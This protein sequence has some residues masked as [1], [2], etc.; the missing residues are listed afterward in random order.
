MDDDLLDLFGD[1]KAAKESK[2]AEV[3]PVELMAQFLLFISERK[4]VEALSLTTEILSYE[5][6]NSMIL[7][8]KRSLTIFIEQAEKE[9][10]STISAEEESSDEADDESSEE[11]SESDSENEACDSKSD[12]K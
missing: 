7:E 1:R 3:A 6:N 9:E 8:Y 5:P 10:N 11:E 2:S 12:H 4:M